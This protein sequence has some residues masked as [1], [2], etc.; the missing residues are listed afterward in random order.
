MYTKIDK[1]KGK[2]K[3]TFKVFFSSNYTGDS[4]S[5]PFP[6]HLIPAM[7]FVVWDNPI[8][9]PYQVYN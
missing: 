2:N 1:K 6:F 3:P 8:L 5:E 4:I 7:V 9:H